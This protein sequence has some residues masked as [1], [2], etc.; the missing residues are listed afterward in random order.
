MSSLPTSLQTLIDQ[1]SRFPGVGKKSAQRLAFF[2]LKNTREDAVAMAKAIIDVKDRI[3]ECSQ[4]HNIAEND[5]CTICGDAKRDH[6]TIC[7]VQDAMDVLAIEKTGRYRGLYHVLGGVL[8]PLNGIGPN[9]LHIDDLM[10][11]LDGIN[12]VIFAINPTRD[13]ETTSLYLSKLL[14]ARGVRISRIAQ[15]LPMG[16]DLEFA[17]E[18]T[19]T[20]ALEGRTIL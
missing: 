8:S 1:L 3:S 14:K 12:E 11:R 6:S 18:L 16:I 7:I 20:K 5:P 19:L 13:G 4:C 15:G 17:D 10:P 2:I 9:D